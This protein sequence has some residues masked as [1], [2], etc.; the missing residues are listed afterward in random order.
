MDKNTINS[1]IIN[2]ALIENKNNNKSVKESPINLDETIKKKGMLNNYKNEKKRIIYSSGENNKIKIHDDKID[3]QNS[4]KLHINNLLKVQL[5]SKIK[6]LELY[7]LFNIIIFAINIFSYFC[8]CK[9]R[10]IFSKLFEVK[11]KV[12]RIGNIKL[13][14]NTFFGKYKNCQIYL[15]DTLIDNNKN[16]YNFSSK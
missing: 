5:Y 1:N 3:F 2:F 10:F 8:C 9:K 12:N 14:S 15:N 11:L 4:K 7:F 16:E 6:F 13:F